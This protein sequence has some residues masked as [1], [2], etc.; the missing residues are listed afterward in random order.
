[1]FAFVCLFERV[2]VC[3]FLYVSACVSVYVCE[4]ARLCACVRAPSFLPPHTFYP[5]RQEVSTDLVKHG[6]EI[7]R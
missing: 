3:L 5:K 1:M 4:C 2:R 7:Y 6:K